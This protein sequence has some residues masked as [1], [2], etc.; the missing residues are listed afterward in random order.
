MTRNN[1]TVTHHDMILPSRSMRMAYNGRSI[2]AA[3]A[4]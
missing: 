3:T 4:P 2:Y 1:T